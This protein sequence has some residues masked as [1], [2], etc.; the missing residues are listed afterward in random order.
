MV[1][2]FERKELQLHLQHHNLYW[3]RKKKFFNRSIETIHSHTTKN[4]AVH[5]STNSMLL[6]ANVNT[7][8][9]I[10]AITPLSPLSRTMICPGD[11]AV[12][13]L[14]VPGGTTTMTVGDEG[15][16]NAACGEEGSVACGGVPMVMVRSPTT[17]VL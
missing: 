6:L 12:R 7:D 8:T 10:L 4:T 1:C 9:A 11:D 5:I 3:R 15:S 13:L 2:R 14:S 16:C 17:L